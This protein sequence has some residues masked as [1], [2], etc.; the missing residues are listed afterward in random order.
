VE[1]GVVGLMRWGPG[2]SKMLKAKGKVA[3]DRCTG[4]V[5]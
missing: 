3:T 2:H 5:V 1:N 4:P